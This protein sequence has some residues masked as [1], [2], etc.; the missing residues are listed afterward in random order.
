M[1]WTDRLFKNKRRFI[2]TMN[3]NRQ[4]QNELFKHGRLGNDEINIVDR[5]SQR[6][7]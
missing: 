3:D 5:S 7:T 6:S 4:S 1:I 2:N